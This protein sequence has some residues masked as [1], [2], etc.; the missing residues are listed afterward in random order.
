MFQCC[1]SD[2]D[3]CCKTGNVSP[4][5][6][7]KRKMEIK[8][9]PWLIQLRQHARAFIIIIHQF[10]TSVFDTNNLHN[11]LISSFSII[12]VHWCLG[13]G[14]AFILKTKTLQR[15]GPHK[16]HSHKRKV[17]FD[18]LVEILLD[19]PETEELLPNS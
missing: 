19:R 10:Y 1:V 4:A 8:M 9:C 5:S 18:M 7:M 12:T 13:G 3:G 16:G 14:G 11:N 2:N 15:N 6:D 17:H